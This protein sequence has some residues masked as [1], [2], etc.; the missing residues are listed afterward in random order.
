MKSITLI[1]A[2]LFSMNA[3]S[4]LD[5]AAEMA[6]KLK[7]FSC[8]STAEGVPNGL[9]TLT[10]TKHMTEFTV[11]NQVVWKV[12]LETEVSS[13]DVIKL[14]DFDLEQFQLIKALVGMATP[15]KAKNI[16]AIK[17]S[18]VAIK[19][20]HEETLAERIERVSDDASGYI[21]L[22]TLNNKNKVVGNSVM[23]AWAGFFKNCK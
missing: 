13:V 18:M 7:V 2:I 21:Y 9:M 10:D 17:L 16:Q 15:K 3:W 4:Q 11:D 23:A 8:A 14:K 1:F 6:A 12:D 5:P 20:D 19:K 22:E